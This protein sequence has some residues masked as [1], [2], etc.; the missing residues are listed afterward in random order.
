MN[1]RWSKLKKDFYN[2]DTDKFNISKIPEIFDVIRH[3]NVKNKHIFIDIDPELIQ[4]LYG[5]AKLLAHF[6]VIN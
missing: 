1:S 2:N 6:V 3:D 4:Q 5:V